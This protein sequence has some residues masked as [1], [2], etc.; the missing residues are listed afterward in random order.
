MTQISFTI[1]NGNSVIPNTIYMPSSDPAVN[2]LSLL[3]SSDTTLQL[4]A[5]TPIPESEITS[6]NNSSLFYLNLAALGLTAAELDGLTFVMQGWNIK[7]FPATQMLCLTPANNL[8]LSKGQNLVTVIDGLRSATAPSGST[9]QLY[10]DFYGAVPVC[11]GALPFTYNNVVILQAPPDGKLDLHAVLAASLQGNTVVQSN[12]D[13]PIVENALALT[14][15]PGP[16]PT[17]ITAGPDTIFTVSFVYADDPLGYG[18][19]T[20]PGMALMFDVRAGDNASG[21][22]ITPPATGARAPA[23]ML[24]APQGQPILGTATGATVGF[25]IANIATSFQAGA[26][27]MLVTYSGVPGYA[28]GA[29]SLVLY[30]EGHVYVHSLVAA[31]NPVVLTD[32]SANVELTWNANGSRLT[33]MPGAINVSNRQS[34]SMPVKESTQFTLIAQGTSPGNYASRDTTVD[35]LPVINSVVASPQFVYHTDFPHDVLLDWVVDSNDPVQLSN[36]VNTNVQDLP[37]S[38][39]TGLTVNQPQMFSIAPNESGLPLFIE[40]NQVVSAFD[41]AMESVSL[42]LAPTGVALSP[43]ANLCALIQQSSNQVL[44]LETITHT[45]Y[46]APLPAGNNPVAV[47]F[48]RDGSKLFVANAGDSTLTVFTVSVDPASNGYLFAQLGNPVS[49]SGVP[50]AL[51]PSTADAQVFVTSNA[52]DGTQGVLDVLAP[53]GAGYVVKNS[54]RFSGTAGSLAVLPSSAQ[55]FIIGAAG[56]VVYVV[57]FDTIHRSYQWVRTIGGFSAGDQLA[58]IAI[59][60]QDS[61]TLLIVCSGSNRVYAVNKEVSSVAGKQVLTVGSKPVRVVVIESGAYA[62]IANAGD[63]TLSL[64]SCFKGDGF[65]SILENSLANGASAQALS[66]SS[67]GNLI[68]AANSQAS[69]SVWKS[70]TFVA[71]ATQLAAT[72][73]TSIAASMQF[74]VSWHNYNIAFQ[75]QGQTPTPG[76]YV[77]DRIAETNV[78]VNETT[79]YTTFAFWPDS[80]QN[81]AIATAYG[82]N[83]LSILDTTDFSTTSTISLSASATCRAVASAVSPFGNMIFVLTTEEGGLYRLV[84]IACN[85]QTASYSI[86]STVTLFTQTES[87]SHALAATSGGASVFITDSAA[88]KLYVVTGGAGGYSL[89]ETSYDCAYMPHVMSCAPDDTQLYIW[90]NEASHSAFARFDIAAATLDNVALPA[91]VSLNI[92][93]MAIAPDGS[94]LYLAD[95]N[96]GGIRVFS[97]DA[98]QNVEN[99]A[100]AGASFPMGVAISPDGSGLFTANAFS[101]NISLASQLG[102]TP[103]PGREAKAALGSGTPYL[104]IFLRDY[105]GEPVSNGS[106]GSGWTLSPD[107]VLYGTAVMPSTD[108]LGQQAN[109]GKDYSNDTT[110]GEINHIYVRGYNTNPGPQTSRVYFYSVDCAVVLLPSQ[111][112]PYTFSFNGQLQNWLDITAAQQGDIAFSVAPLSWQPSSAY[113]HYCVVAWVDNTA[114]PMPPDLSTFGNFASQ[115][116]LGTFIVGHPNMGWR[117]IVAAKTPAAFMNAQ[118][119]VTGFTAGGQVTVSL[120]MKNIAVDPNATIQF[121]LVNSDN[122]ISYN[123]PVQPINT[124]TFSQ[125]IDWPANAPD[126]ILTYTYIPSGPLNMKEQITAVTSFLPPS[127]MLKLLHLRAPHTLIEVRRHGFYSVNEMVLGA[128]RFICPGV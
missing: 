27:L 5:G 96:F 60:A 111:W 92:Y 41:L 123:S 22:L 97:T 69:L 124:N 2:K 28:D 24:Q 84:A 36:S 77:Y 30:K 118:T 4:T 120:V 40:R 50:V 116:D 85:V 34:Y 12:N 117:N 51:Q 119:R 65:C 6:D 76:L 74:L 107:I 93:A 113:P 29:F 71:G 48:S 31:Q 101:N 59:A 106:T 35:I 67:Q 14:L 99:V 125:T 26:T 115:N 63:N 16:N 90:M 13:Y 8:V 128:V 53:V 44:I 3:I 88:R 9:A 38:Y 94:R 121:T 87:A 66:A 43:T 17:S 23:W 81:V 105:F 80:K 89:Q 108:V 1:M 100:M 58:D 112:S 122:S 78:L 7:A 21:W 39:T 64:I 83:L 98:M 55:I 45:P 73:V 42:S 37:P 46:G 68:Y 72:Q 127:A 75:S 79:Q 33:L 95:T 15:A 91:G 54:V 32:G 114:S 47:A 70:R 56:S 104:G 103:A 86:V 52:T 62:Y 102:A 126:P 19:L 57:G 82:D 110:L 25:N 18:A 11:T 10:M 49:L 109:Y 61:A 20:S